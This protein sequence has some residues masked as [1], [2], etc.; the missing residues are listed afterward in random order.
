M[1][2][3]KS[4]ARALSSSTPIQNNVKKF[5]SDEVSMIH[6]DVASSSAGETEPAKMKKATILDMVIESIKAVG[7]PRKG[8]SYQAI[9]K[10]ISDNKEIDSIRLKVLLKM[11]LKKGIDQGILGRPFRS[12]TVAG[13]LGYFKLVQTKPVKPS[14]TAVKKTANKISAKKAKSPIQGTKVSKMLHELPAIKIKPVKAPSKAKA[15]TGKKIAKESQK[16]IEKKTA[17]KATAT[18]KPAVKKPAVKKP[19]AKKPAG[20]KPAAKKTAEAAT[21]VSSEIEAEKPSEK[22][23]LKAKV[24]NKP[25]KKATATTN[26][27]TEVLSKPAAEKPVK[28]VPVKADVKEETLAKKATATNKP[29]TEMPL[30]AEAEKKKVPS[31]TKEGKN[32]TTKAASK[33]KAS[34]L[35][36]ESIQENN[37]N[38]T[39]LERQELSDTEID[40]RKTHKRMFFSSDTELEISKRE[41]K[42]KKKLKK[43]LPIK[44]KKV[45]TKI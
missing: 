23:L 5:V 7:E 35:L 14:K 29:T 27:T 45:A 12:A 25:E 15:A 32:T 44:A 37:L 26:P 22:A 3:F 20:R 21:K 2:N 38:D 17:T 40:N 34:K 41:E 30:K 6:I 43:K 8:A 10:W 31:N 11:A 36:D 16:K 4:R 39:K 28:K 13:A 18:K 9:K 33:V 19:A 24:Q 42:T 1:N